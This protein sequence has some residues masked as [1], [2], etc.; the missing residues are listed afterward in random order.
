[1]GK[2]EKENKEITIQFEDGTTAKIL[3]IV[4]L[5]I[6]EH[7]KKLSAKIVE[8]QEEIKNS[9]E[10]Y[11]VLENRIISKI[12]TFEYECKKAERNNDKERAVFY[13]D[14]MKN[15]KKLLEG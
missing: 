13:S 4:D 7:I 15:F 5:D 12:V 1:M 9:K 8:Q 3:K 14:L 10:K 11:F 2:S 6:N